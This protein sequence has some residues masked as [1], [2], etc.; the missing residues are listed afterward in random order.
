MDP[1][2]EVGILIYEVG[3]CFPIL[4]SEFFKTALSTAVG[5]NSKTMDVDEFSF[6]VLSTAVDFMYGIEIPEGFNNGDDLK[7]LLHMADLYLMEDLKEA[8]GFLI[9]KDLNKENVFDTSQLAD[10]FRAVA[11]GEQCAEFFYDNANTIEDEKLAEMGEGAVMAS[12]ARKFA[13]ESKKQEKESKKQ[14]K[15]DDWMIKLFGEKSDLKRL[16]D[17]GSVDD[18]KGYVMSRIKPKMFVRC[19]KSSIWTGCSGNGTWSGT[20]STVN[21][22]HVGFV[23]TTNYSTHVEVRWLTLKA[24]DP[25]AALIG[26]RSS[27]PYECL[28]LLTSPVTFACS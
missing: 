15:R 4:R 26:E 7:S 8:A 10:K 13:M 24:G 14:Q 11:L 22:G 18:Y 12:L 20:Q 17:F 25:G 2:H 5:N 23:Q 3:N 1:Q 9:G 16:E 6:E 21:E 19:N 27:G 28:D